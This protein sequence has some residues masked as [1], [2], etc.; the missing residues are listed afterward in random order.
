MD[1]HGCVQ[2]SDNFELSGAPV[3]TEVARGDAL[4]PRFSSRTKNECPFCGLFSAIFWVLFCFVFYISVLFVGDFSLW[5]RPQTQ[6][7][8][9]G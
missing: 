4:P 5:N 2:G 1:T 9:A 7:G 8:S 6:C 3:P